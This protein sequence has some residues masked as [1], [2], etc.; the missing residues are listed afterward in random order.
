MQNLLTEDMLLNRKL[1]NTFM[2]VNSSVEVLDVEP[3]TDPSVPS[4]NGRYL[5]VMTKD[6]GW[7]HVYFRKDNGKLEWY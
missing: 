3:E 4:E 2:E 5:K 1:L 6:H 7:L